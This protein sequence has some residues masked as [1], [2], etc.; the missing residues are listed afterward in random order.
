M[1]QPSRCLY[2]LKITKI[3]ILVNTIFILQSDIFIHCFQDESLIDSH[4]CMSVFLNFGLLV[5]VQ[6]IKG[7]RSWGVDPVTFYSF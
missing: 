7:H 1:V 4:S 6:V 2:S 5:Q 3:Y